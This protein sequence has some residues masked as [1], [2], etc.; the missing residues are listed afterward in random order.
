M[1]RDFVRNMGCNPVRWLLNK[2]AKVNAVDKA[3]CTPLFIAARNNDAVVAQML[4]ARG[5]SVTH[6]STIGTPLHEAAG[7]HSLSVVKVLLNAGAPVRARAP[8][9]ESTPL[10]EASHSHAL[11]VAQLLLKH[12]ARIEDT[13][14][15]GRTPLHYA[16]ERGANPQFTRWLLDKGANPNARD[17]EGNTPL[18]ILAQSYQD[19]LGH[20]AILRRHGRLSEIERDRARYIGGVVGSARVLLIGGADPS[21]RNLAGQTPID[22]ARE[23]GFTEMV[24]LLQEHKRGRGK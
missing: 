3:N 2:G 20:E 4:I 15:R 16:C 6:Q 1:L 8:G 12:G 10:H 22:I 13:D 5:A 14:S 7:W 18:H 9:S 23:V 17:K 19:L 24:Q 21:I 11:D